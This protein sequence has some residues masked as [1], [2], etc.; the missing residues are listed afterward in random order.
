MPTAC[1]FEGALL[2]NEQELGKTTITI[3]FASTFG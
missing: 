3:V 2:Q 1:N